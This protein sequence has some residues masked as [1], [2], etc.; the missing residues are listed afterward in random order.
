[1]PLAE[2]EIAEGPSGRVEALLRWAGS[3]RSLIHE[4]VERRPPGEFRYMEPFAG[5][6]CLFFATR[7][8][9]AVL[10]D[11]NAS[12]IETYRCLRDH[13]LDV[14]AQVHAWKSDKAT[15]YE[16]RAESEAEMDP[17][18]RA[19]RFIYLNRLC[20]N[21]VYRT[22]RRGE[23]NVPYGSRAGA[24]PA[25]SRFVECGRLLARAE[26]IADDFEVVVAGAGKGDFVYLDPPYSRAASDAY[27]VYG[28][29]SFDGGDLERLLACLKRLDAAGAR[30]LLSYKD[31]PEL[32]ALGRGWVRADV[33]VR[34]QVGGR[35]EARTSRQEVLVANYSFRDG[36]VLS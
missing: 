26:L 1:M 8:A 23:F 18:A 32:E 31:T 33:S 24:L 5:S 21:G 13:P 12:L 9:N 17:V 27:G 20:F 35:A 3:K 36:S 4:L 10:G 34:T 22:N 16:V 25:A 2:A 15:Y 11:R 14:A 19:A 6:A 30:V 7:P 29:G 28:Y